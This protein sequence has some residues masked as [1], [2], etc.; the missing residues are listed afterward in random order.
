M[1]ACAVK[2]WEPAH[3]PSCPSARLALPIKDFDI[4]CYAWRRSTQCHIHQLRLVGSTAVSGSSVPEYLSAEFLSETA[5]V[6]REQI[7]LSHVGVDLR[8][9]F[10]TINAEKPGKKKQNM[11]LLSEAA[12]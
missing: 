6:L 10:A 4:S 11:S 5:V 3:T 9:V 2:R 7:P 8:G 1:L 12:L